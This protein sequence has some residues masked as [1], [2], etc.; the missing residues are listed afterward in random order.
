LVSIIIPCYNEEAVIGRTLSHLLDGADLSDIE[1][2]VCC[3]GCRDRTAEIAREFGP[4][5]QVLET[6]SGS[7]P[8]ALNMGDAVAK[9]F[10]RI[11]L[12]ADVLMN[13]ST[14]V[15]IIR[16]LEDKTV[17]AVS[18]TIR[19]DLTNRNWF[20]RSFYEIS[21]K[22]PYNLRGMIRG[23]IYAMSEEGR[24]RFSEFPKIISDDGFATAQFARH[25]QRILEDCSFTIA[26]PK[27]LGS[28]IRIES[29]SI[30][31][32]KELRLTQPDLMRRHAS[33]EDPR[34]RRSIYANLVIQPLLWPKLAV[35]AVIKA[36]AT[37]R[38][39]GQLKKIKDYRWER[40]ES[41]RSENLP[42]AG[43]MI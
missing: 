21:L 25:E 40:D 34:L 24:R 30:L 27:D 39:K 2:I 36:V 4:P 1:V 32:T 37:V 16:A 5:V 23:G 11:Y 14:V 31:G 33:E 41:S 22:M 42:K 29:R 26:P 12:D 17:L 43:S 7:K 19:V 13:Y 8:L 6:P 28:L 38:A 10:P 35:Y 18:P 9:T 20:I 15:S 3:N